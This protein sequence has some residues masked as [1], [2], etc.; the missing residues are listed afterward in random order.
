[1]ENVRVEDHNSYESTLNSYRPIL[2]ASP[3]VLGSKFS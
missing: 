1:M 3:S 2:E